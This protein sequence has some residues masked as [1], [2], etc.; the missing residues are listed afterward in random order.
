M[1]SSWSS[2]NIWQLCS[3]DVTARSSP[4]KYSFVLGQ[5]ATWN[6]C[7][8]RFLVLAGLGLVYRAEIH[9]ERF[10]LFARVVHGGKI[11]SENRE[12]FFVY[13]F[14]NSVFLFESKHQNHNRQQ[15]SQNIPPCSAYSSGDRC[16]FRQRPTGSAA[17]THKEER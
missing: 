17:I 15:K 14:E 6:V 2:G 10:I 11:C 13:D 12:Y 5:V 8:D 1:S 3:G 7:A 4:I 16:Q 9:P